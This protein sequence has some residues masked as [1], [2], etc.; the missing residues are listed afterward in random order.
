MT[1]INSSDIV[2]HC[3][4]CEIDYV[5]HQCAPCPLC[6]LRARLE[7]AA[8][9]ITKSEPYRIVDDVV[10]LEMQAR[11]NNLAAFGWTLADFRVGGTRRTAIMAIRCTLRS[12]AGKTTTRSDTAWRWRPSRRSSPTTWQSGGS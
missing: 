1:I 3:E 9:E 12:C 5:G 2:N 8:N 6:R 4:A 11:I 7:D 10:R